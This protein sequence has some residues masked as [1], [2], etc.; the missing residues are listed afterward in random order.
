[1][2]GTR[3]TADRLIDVS[4]RPLAYVNGAQAATKNVA[5]NAKR[6]S[7]TRAI[8]GVNIAE[9]LTTHHGFPCDQPPIEIS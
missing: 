3:A 4:N 2:N 5:E 9:N 8:V 1:M 7:R 6:S